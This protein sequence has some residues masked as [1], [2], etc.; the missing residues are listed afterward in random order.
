MKE[1]VEHALETIR[2]MLAMHRGN[3]E[4]VSAAEGIVKVRLLGMCKGCPLAGL[5]L[6]AGIEEHLKKR[7]PGVRFV[8]AVE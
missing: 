8:E 5:T 4:L 3:I 7:V 6:K 2:P 1:A